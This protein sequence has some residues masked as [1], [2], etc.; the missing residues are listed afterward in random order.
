MYLQTKWGDAPP[1]VAVLRCSRWWSDPRRL[2][3]D[4]QTPM[5]WEE[6]EE[7]IEVCFSKSQSF[8]GK[9]DV[10]HLGRTKL[11]TEGPL[12]HG[13][14]YVYSDSAGHF[15]TFAP[16]Q[17]CSTA[18]MYWTTVDSRKFYGAAEIKWA[19]HLLLQEMGLNHAANFQVVSTR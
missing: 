10:R 7:W 14:D 5:A 11:S 15:V 16:V 13:L 17:F 9:V 2:P 6:W 8:Q 18:V 12:S 4:P 19:C 1:P 3:S